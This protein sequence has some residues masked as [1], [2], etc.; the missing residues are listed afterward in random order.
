LHIVLGLAALYFMVGFLALALADA[1]ERG[2]LPALA[3]S[4]IAQ[5]ACMLALR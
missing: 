5:V 2:H 4:L 1:R 3:L